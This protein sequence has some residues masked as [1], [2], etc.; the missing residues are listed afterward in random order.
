MGSA[1]PRLHLAK[2]L[3]T[4]IAYMPQSE[5]KR[6]VGFCIIPNRGNAYVGAGSPSIFGGNLGILR[7][8]TANSLRR[9]SLFVVDRYGSDRR[10]RP[11]ATR[12]TIVH[13]SFDDRAI[14]SDYGCETPS[15]Y[16]EGRDAAGRGRTTPATSP[17]TP[18]QEQYA[19]LAAHTRRFVRHSRHIGCEVSQS[20][21]PNN[22]LPSPRGLAALC[23]ARHLC[24]TAKRSQP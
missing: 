8:R 5:P 10:I 20:D 7:D 24:R 13:D 11:D 18:L 22:C 1:F 4:S 9:C 17:I 21:G 23:C 19:S 14:I 3:K 15:P 2:R 6:P 12:R 16:I